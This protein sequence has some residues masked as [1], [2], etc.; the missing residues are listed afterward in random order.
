M[1]EEEG[2]TLDDAKIL[3]GATTK[4]LTGDIPGA[5]RI[6]GG[7]LDADHDGHVT[8]EDVIRSKRKIF[9]AVLFLA[10][11]FIGY[12]LRSL[13]TFFRQAA[14]TDSMSLTLVT[15]LMWIAL[16]V[17]LLTA[18]L[19]TWLIV[20]YFVRTRQR[21]QNELA[22]QKQNPDLGTVVKSNAPPTFAAGVTIDLGPEIEAAEKEKAA[23]AAA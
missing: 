14:L 4:A 17:L 21:H 16:Y 6:A 3:A 2:L 20:V 7:I 19:E 1:I 5:A 12:Y 23:D 9:W 22:F 10:T 13:G 18:A 15:V 11:W 8:P